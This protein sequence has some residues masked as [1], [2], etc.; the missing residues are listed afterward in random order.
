MS[1]KK[2]HFPK[3]GLSQKISDLS[4][5]S[6]ELSGGDETMIMQTSTFGGQV[7]SS[8]RILAKAVKVASS[9][10]DAGSCVV[11]RWLRKEHS[12]EKDTNVQT[13]ATDMSDFA[14]VTAILN[15]EA[16]PEYASSVRRS[17]IS[18]RE[19]EA[20]PWAFECTV[21]SPPLHGSYNILFPILFGDTTKWLLKVPSAVESWNDAAAHNLRSEASTM[22]YLKGK[23]LPVPEVYSFD[24]SSDNS[25]KCP[26]ILMEFLEGRPLYE[27]EFSS[28]YMEP[29]ALLPSPCMFC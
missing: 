9:V 18:S 13:A 15:F 14:A 5:Q 7:T 23:G 1:Q 28:R 19:I 21:E 11:K 10:F 4:R 2:D 29:H 24:T 26:F 22:R 6:P 12:K 8:A 17:R 27:G 3:H 20:T 16:I 25:L